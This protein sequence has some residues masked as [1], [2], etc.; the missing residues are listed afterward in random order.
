VPVSLQ[1]KFIVDGEW[2][3]SLCD[4][5]APDG[6]VGALPV[7]PF[8]A[9]LSLVEALSFVV[10]SDPG[11]IVTRLRRSL[12]GAMNNQRLVTR[13]CTLVWAG[14]EFSSQPWDK[15]DKVYVTG[16][17]C[18]WKVSLG[19]RHGTQAATSW[20]SKTNSIH[21]YIIS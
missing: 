13:N 20:T 7:D 6:K 12:Q 1:Y 15:A 9:C 4:G 10:Y 18:G 2:T 8:T 3:T 5:L 11:H 16:S 17:F 21:H 14:N 19:N